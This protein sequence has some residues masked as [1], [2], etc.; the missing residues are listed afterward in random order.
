MKVT[1]QF[2]L[3]LA[4]LLP[5]PTISAP[6]PRTFKIEIHSAEDERGQ[7]SLITQHD[8]ADV[9]THKSGDGKSIHQ[10]LCHLPPASHL[11]FPTSALSP[12][13]LIRFPL[14]PF[15]YFSSTLLQPSHPPVRVL[16][17]SSLLT[18]LT[19]FTPSPRTM[20]SG[21]RLL[22]HM[23]RLLRV[24]QRQLHVLG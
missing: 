7:Q 19:P 11:P 2:I 18:E 1:R 20:S 9:F 21:P 23:V 12:N 14:S 8:V 24:L 5:A 17:P 6:N 10:P 15:L 3:L 16:T 22:L 4:T 13:L